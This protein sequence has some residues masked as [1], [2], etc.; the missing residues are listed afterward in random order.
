MFITFKK[1]IY[2]SI[3]LLLFFLIICSPNL[4]AHKNGIDT[5]KIKA[6]H[7]VAESILS[8]RSNIQ[9][10][11]PKLIELFK[12]LG[13]LTKNTVEVAKIVFLG[14]TYKNDQSPLT[15]MVEMLSEAT[16]L[17]YQTPGYFSLL[18]KTLEQSIVED[19]SQ[20][21]GAVYEIETAL[22][23]EQQSND[24]I[25][26]YFNEPIIAG[27]ARTEI[28]IVTKHQWI[29]CKTAVK[30]LRNQTKQLKRQVLT[31]KELLEEYNKQHNTSLSYLVSFKNDIPT[32]LQAWL[33][34]NKI[35]FTTTHYQ[36]S[37]QSWIDHLP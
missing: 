27:N 12:G 29:E 3:Y 9:K 35:C 10:M 4:N 31:H 1:R 30:I 14:A 26:L 25:V 23:I 21:T 24:P 20:F 33:H 28:D 32:S 8:D 13:S 37:S 17:F 5:T 2:M 18:S 6:I 7:K 34:K 19:A 22:A 36:T 16:E 15:P 11:R